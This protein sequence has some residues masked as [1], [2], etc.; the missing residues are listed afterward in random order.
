MLEERIAGKLT[1]GREH[2]TPHGY[3]KGT[4]RPSTGHRLVHRG[5][6]FSGLATCG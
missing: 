3:V 1:G 4:A 6:R 5:V 2:G